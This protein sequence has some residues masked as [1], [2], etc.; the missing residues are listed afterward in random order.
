[1]GKA[2]DRVEAMSRYWSLTKQG[3]SVSTSSSQA[4]GQR[5]TESKRN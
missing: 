4:V 2:E 5:L 3:Y 1:M